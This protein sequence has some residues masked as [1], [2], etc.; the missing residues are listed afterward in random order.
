MILS[1]ANSAPDRSL[2]HLRGFTMVEL[3]VAL[4]ISLMG[5]LA[6]M[7]IYVG[8]ETG[9]RATGSLAEAQSGGN[10]HQATLGVMVGFAVMMIL[11]VALG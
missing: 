2:K 5:A 9:K 3:L 10:T 6:I 8:S 11:D 7:Q 4:V 1:H